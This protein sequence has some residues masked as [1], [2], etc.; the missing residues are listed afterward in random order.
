[1]H[2]AEWREAG[3]APAA[4]A[5]SAALSPCLA[6]APGLAAAP[7][8]SFVQIVGR[9]AGWQHKGPAL[10]PPAHPRS[11]RRSSTLSATMGAGWRR[12]KEKVRESMPGTHT[13]LTSNARWGSQP[14]FCGATHYVN[15]AKLCEGCR[16]PGGPRCRPSPSSPARLPGCQKL[17]CN[18][19][20]GLDAEPAPAA[21]ALAPRRRPLAALPPPA[22][23]GPSASGIRPVQF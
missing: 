9:S 12:W 15:D 13:D 7:R 18:A 3:S 20:C 16:W 11:A 19:E 14:A 23:P 2:A 5:A 1:M 8:S 22:Q 21:A 6:R 10:A 17:E 4:G